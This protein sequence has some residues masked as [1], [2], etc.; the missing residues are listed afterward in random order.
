M[1]IAQV[2]NVDQIGDSVVTVGVPGGGGAGFPA[3]LTDATTVGPLAVGDI[4]TLTRVMN[5]Y[6]VS[7]TRTGPSVG[8]GVLLGSELAPNPGFE[9]GIEGGWPDGW[10]VAWNYLTGEPNPLSLSPQRPFA[11][12]LHATLRAE[13]GDWSPNP[14]LVST[15]AR[16]V[17]AGALHRLSAWVAADVVT[18]TGFNVQLAILTG[19]T[20]E[21]AV[22]FGDGT[23][24]VLATVVAP[25]SAYQLVLADY[26]IPTG[27]FYARPV[28]RFAADQGAELTVLIDDV[29][30]KPRI[31]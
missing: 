2:R 27:H 5:S 24:S 16:P 25:G 23:Y 10:R 8:G 29:S 26:T 12:S 21:D 22:F 1:K 20:P 11:G 28:V 18:A 31:A 19:A 3:Y 17:T 9:S 30:L 7:A 15:D 6:E 4:V 13:P 14:A